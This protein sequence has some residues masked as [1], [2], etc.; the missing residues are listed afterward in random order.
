MFEYDTNRPLAAIDRPNNGNAIVPMDGSG[1][2]ID[3]AGFRRHLHYMAKGGT[4]LFIGGG[5]A[6]EFVNMNAAERRRVWEIAVEE[7]KGKSLVVAIPW[8]PASTTEMIAWFKMG[9]DMGFDAG[10]LY[11]GAMDGRGGDGLFIHECERYFRDILEAVDYPIFLCGYHGGEIIDSPTKAVPP[12]LLL[13]LLDEYPHIAGIT[14][15]YTRND[16]ELRQFIQAVGSRVPVRATGHKNWFERCELGVYGYHSIQPSIAPK[17][18]SLMLDAHHQGNQEKAKTL[19]D[20]IQAL[21]E[22]VHDHD[23]YYPRTIK[24]ILTHLG[25]DAGSIRRPY[26][27]MDEEHRREMVKRIDELHLETYE[28]LPK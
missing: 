1:E 23:Y 7:L 2:T 12:E 5:H 6:T 15:P 10:Q 9:K 18:C 8:G 4:N 25:F 28:D 20:V 26:Q 13:K 11:P 16:E 22:I 17:I 27:G 24:P 21:G 19:S 3:E 14:G